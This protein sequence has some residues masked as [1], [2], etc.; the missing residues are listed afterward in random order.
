MRFTFILLL[1]VTSAS[2]IIAQNTTPKNKIT[3]S[4]Y[5]LLSKL[6]PEDIIP[7]FIQG[8]TRLIKV[9]I[10]NAGEHIKY[11]TGDIVSAD[12][13]KQTILDL[14]AENFI[15]K[16][17]CPTGKITL[18]NDNMVLNNNVDSA[19]YGYAP[20]LQ[21]YDGTGVVVGV[22][23][24]PFDIH[25]G[26]FK[27]ADGNSKIK[28]IWDQALLDG[29]HPEPYTYG[30]ECDSATIADDDCPINDDN[31]LWYSHGSGVAGVA[32]SSGLAANQ[33]RGVAPNADLILVSFDFYGNFLSRIADAIAYIYDRADELN[34]PCVINTSLGSYAGSHDGKD[35][36]S[37]TIDNLI[38]EHSGR[39]LVAAAGNLG[40][41]AFHLGYDVTPTEQF[42]WFTK[43]S[44]LNQVYFQLY[45]DSSEFNNVQFSI[46]ADNPA[47]F[48]NIGSTVD[49]NMLD[50]FDLSDGDIESIEFEIP[51]GGTGTVNA[52]LMD[53]VYFLDFEIVPD[54]ATYF[55]KFTTSGTGHFDMWNTEIATGFS[56]YVTSGLPDAAT[57]PEIIN[58][59]LPDTDQ[60]IVS[61][62]QCSENVITVGS[63]VNRD[64]MTNYYGDSPLLVDTVG[65]L[66]ISSS[67]GPTRDGRIKPDI[68]ASGARILSTESQVLS[69]WLI[70]LDAANYMSPD[71][72]H[73]LFNGTS[74]ASPIVAGIAALYLQQFPNAW[75]DDIKSAILTTANEDEFT[76]DILPDNKWGYGKANAFRALIVPFVDIEENNANNKIIAYPN[77]SGGIIYINGIKNKSTVSIY[78]LI[79]EKLFSTEINVSDSSIDISS[80]NNGIYLMSVND[81]QNNYSLK[82]IIVK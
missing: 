67:T 48:I 46:A 5:K 76:S 59:K 40:N 65:Q 37:Q 16:I 38:E 15:D 33:Y 20:L 2:N 56:N 23:D 10:I 6:N 28:F 22:I 24:A 49:F 34:K 61:S 81:G 39:S 74:F 12:I 57:L 45:A 35:L 50:D 51:G 25:H 55:W 41:N 71:G 72:K 60:S 36:L 3:L 8:D 63:Y 27:D 73:Y 7:V 79:N 30:K 70:S 43:L 64:T 77:P 66:F 44:Y 54:D 21:G 31:E 14:N 1:I 69:D 29:P 17:E 53:G 9:S 80:F 52:Q 32:A 19:Y 78:N 75:Y 68:S 47:G 18:L 13:S 58:Y 42:T 62:W 82:I 26:D 11:I 4:T